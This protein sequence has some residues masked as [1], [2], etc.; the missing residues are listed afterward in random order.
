MAQ[1]L[2]PT[3]NPGLPASSLSLTR[4]RCRRATVNVVQILDVAESVVK[5]VPAVGNILEG[6]I[7]TV[8]KT[9]IIAQVRFSLIFLLQTTEL[10]KQ[11]VKTCKD[12]CI[13]LA[14]RAAIM[15]GVVCRE[16]AKSRAVRQQP[17][18]V[19]ERVSDLI[20]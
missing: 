20:E 4:Q 17:D 9:W 13:H 7:A 3:R 5:V 16:V 15:T 14:E 1:V 12:E 10:W 11:S 19:E 18:S 6:S 8:R 2:V